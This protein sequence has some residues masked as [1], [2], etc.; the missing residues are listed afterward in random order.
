LRERNDRS[1]LMLIRQLLWLSTPAIWDCF[2]LVSH[3]SR[4]VPRNDGVLK[5]WKTS[6]RGRN[7][8]SNLMLI[9]QLLWLSTPAIWDCF[10]LVSHASRLVPR[11]DG[12]LKKW[13]TSLRER[14]DRSNL[15]LTRQLL[16]LSTPAIWDCFVLVSHAS[17]LVPRNDG[18]LKWSAS[19]RREERPKQSHPNPPTTL[20]EYACNLGLLRPRLS[21]FE[22]RSSQ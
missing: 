9:R 12:V 13:K 19:W 2:V 21:C 3:A 4:L 1:N 20:V 10:V 8:R 5:K 17:R 6:L 7:D 22:T 11:N 18:K 14:N 16:W 15:I